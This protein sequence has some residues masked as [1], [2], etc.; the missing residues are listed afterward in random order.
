[1]LHPPA[2]IGEASSHFTNQRTIPIPVAADLAAISFIEDFGNELYVGFGTKVY[3]WNE[4]S[5]DW[6]AVLH[7]L[8]GVATAR[9]VTRL[10]T[11]RTLYLIIACGDAGYSYFDGTDWA[12]VTAQKAVF[13][14]WWDYKVWALAPDGL[15]SFTDDLAGAWTEDAWLPLPEDSATSMLVA[16]TGLEQLPAIHVISK[17]GSLW[18]HNSADSRFVRTTLELPFHPDTGVG[19]TVWR[20]SIYIPSGLALYQ[21]DSR[22][23]VA[24]VGLDRDAGLPQNR[25][26]RIIQL[27]PKQRTLIALVEGEST[28]VEQDFIT[29]GPLDSYF[30]LVYNSTSKPS[31]IL[32]RVGSGWQV[33]WSGGQD[34][35]T[36]SEPLELTT[37]HI[38]SAYGEYR[39]WFGTATQLW[40]IDIPVHVINPTNLP[41][42]L[43]AYYGETITPWYNANQAE[44]LKVALNYL[45]E[46]RN[47]SE[48][49]AHVLIDAAFD[50]DEA[51]SSWQSLVVEV[52]GGYEDLDLDDSTLQDAF[53]FPASHKERCRPSPTE[54][55][56]VQ[57]YT[58]P[59]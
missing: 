21:V 40:Y 23:V 25:S 35:L 3:K 28:A 42:Q 9:L 45:V 15:M 39:L 30:P 48:D 22:A 44:T 55:S 59:V 50:Y 37:G 32:E 57:G 38:S 18:L 46:T 54:G 51:E 26:G 7:T 5:T 47:L 14:V 49:G 1:M 36:P 11:A 13:M 20:G 10:G 53:Y 31:T 52:D 56:V 43:Y 4:A 41:S 8:P 16:D 2:A 34:G 24:E 33:L 12:D 17:E 27:I 19:S 6:S 58:F 29:P